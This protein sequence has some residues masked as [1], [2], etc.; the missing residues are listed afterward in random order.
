M[1]EV[2]HVHAFNNSFSHCK[3]CLKNFHCIPRKDLVSLR[4]GFENGEGHD[5]IFVV[6]IL[7]LTTLF[8]K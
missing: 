5:S 3:S 7:F 6:C 4:K 8:K 1:G 2:E